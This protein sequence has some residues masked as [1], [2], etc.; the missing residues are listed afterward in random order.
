MKIIQ[1]T[2]HY[3]PHLGGMEQRVRDLSE[4][5][6]KKG[7]E[8]EV[9]TSDYQ[10]KKNKIPS[11]KNLKINY[12]KSFYLAHNPISLSLP[13]K[14][15]K[16]ENTIFHLHL[17]DAY[18]SS[19][20]YILF[21][22]KKLPYVAHIRGD[23][24]TS[25]KMGFLL[26]LYKKIFLKRI[27]RNANKVITLNEDYK[28]MFI[29]RYNLDKSKVAVIPNATNFN[30]VKKT[31]KD[32]H[33][34]ARLLFVGRFSVDKNLPQ[35]IESLAYIKNKNFIL[36]LVGEGEELPRMNKVIESKKLEK[37][38][39][40]LGQLNK[41][42]LYKEYIKSDIVLLPSKVEC[43]SS[44]LLEA[45]ATATPIIASNIPGT[46]AI[47]KNNY[48]G[49]LVKPTPKKIA[50]AIN[51]LIENKSL[52]ESL[53]RNGLKEIQKYSWDKIVE[54]TEKVYEEVLNDC[55]KNSKKVKDNG[56]K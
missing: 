34:P 35:L 25:G 40:F 6:A 32:L 12:L 27:L 3:P 9:L 18:F 23:I 51:K 5:L 11:R 14:I 1:I 31:R 45:M 52:R 47:I 38:V 4:R 8:V 21:K 29:K 48:N 56:K 54:Q 42:D 19:V 36:N 43:F 20:S 41:E 33:T 28:D 50:E 37:K 16:Q 2:P 17:I 22:L 53:A 24:Q 7:N 15:K 10:C 39:K 30:V 13:F 44:V 55:N 26:P 46:R 49:I